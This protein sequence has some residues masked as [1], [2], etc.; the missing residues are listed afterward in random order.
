[1]DD[2]PKSA[3]NDGL[4]PVLTEEQQ[5]ELDEA[6]RMLLGLGAATRRKLL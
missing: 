4:P 5:V 3:D 1:M 6:A 2:Q